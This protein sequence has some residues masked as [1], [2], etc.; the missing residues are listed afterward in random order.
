MWNVAMFS[1][2]VAISSNRCFESEFLAF[3]S[4]VL[5]KLKKFYFIAKIWTAIIEAEELIRNENE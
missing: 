1:L 3:L 4:Y 2:I 5:V